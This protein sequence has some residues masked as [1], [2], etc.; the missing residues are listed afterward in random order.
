MSSFF[1]LT[2][3]ERKSYLYFSVF[4]GVLVSIKFLYP[5]ESETSVLSESM[6]EIVP[7]KEFVKSKRFIP[8]TD[9]KEPAKSYPRSKRVIGPFGIHKID[10]NTMSISDWNKLGFS[11]KQSTGI[12]KYINGVGGLDSLGQLRNLYIVSK[13]EQDSLIFHGRIS[14]ENIN[15][16]V[17]SDLVKLNGIG[18]VLAKRI[19]KFRQVLGGYHSNKQLTEVYGLDS[20]VVKRIEARFLFSKEVNKLN[21]NSTGYDELYMHPYITKKQAKAIIKLR[22]LKY[23]ENKTE[24][25]D[26]FSDSL[27][28]KKIDPYLHL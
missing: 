15:A 13:N 8:E 11:Q 21:V 6:I 16:S 17:E 1:R 14:K 19:L 3:N 12:Y 18:P 10:P 4:I 25:F 9:S 5:V 22:S 23:I 27:K 2:K 20:V 24:L 28:F 26:V 7:E